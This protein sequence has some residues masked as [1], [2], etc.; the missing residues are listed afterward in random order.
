MS[1]LNSLSESQMSDRKEYR[2][3][4]KRITNCFRHDQLV[5][6]GQ[7]LSDSLMDDEDQR[8][9]IEDSEEMKEYV[10]NFRENVKQRLTAD[11]KEVCEVTSQ[12]GVPIPKSNGTQRL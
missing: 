12:P 6:Q 10:R 8:V 5:E 4:L 11:R 1:V 3:L 9:A 2:R 7:E